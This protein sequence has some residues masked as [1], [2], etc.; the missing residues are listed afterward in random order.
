MLHL[1]QFV[2]VNK[3][4]DTI[5]V[6]NNFLEAENGKIY[7]CNNCSFWKETYLKYCLVCFKKNRKFNVFLFFLNSICFAFFCICA[8]IYTAY[9]HTYAPNMYSGFKVIKC[10]SI[11][12]SIKEFKETPAIYSCSYDL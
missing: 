1:F 8:E 6:N 3:N 2:T 12:N 5:P 10:M 11:F 7:K 9:L 4:W